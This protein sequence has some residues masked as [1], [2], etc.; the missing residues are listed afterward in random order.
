MLVDIMSILDEEY[1]VLFIL[2]NGDFLNVMI[3][4]NKKIF[5]IKLKIDM[6]VYFIKEWLFIS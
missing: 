1:N 4:K 6:L 5:V 3:W 2:G